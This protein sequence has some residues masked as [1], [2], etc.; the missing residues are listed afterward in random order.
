[1]R[2]KGAGEL[3]LGDLFDAQA[4]RTPDVTAVRHGAVGLTFGELADRVDRLAERLVRRGTRP[5][6][7]VALCVGRGV[8]MVT[9]LLAIVRAGGVLVPLDPRHPDERLRLLLRDCAAPLVLT[10]RDLAHRTSASGAD[11]VFVDAGAPGGAEPVP[12]D[13][14]TPV[15][16]AG[17][18]AAP[19][20]AV[21]G[22]LPLNAA[23]L[24]YASGSSGVPEGV[25][26]THAGLTD[27]F[28]RHRARFIG[29]ATRDAGG[30]RLRVAH[31]AALSSDA[32]WVPLLW[33][34]A[35]HELHVVDHDTHED[36]AAMLAYV[37]RHRID[38][39]DETPSLLRPLVAAGL[40]DA[41]RHRPSVI[42][43]GGGALDDELRAALAAA[44]GTR[45][46][47]RYGPAEATVDALVRPVRPGGRPP[48]GRPSTGVRARVLDG[49]LRP[50]PAGTP[51]ELYLAGPGLARGYHG[52]PGPTAARFTADPHGPAGSRLY[53]TGDLVRVR[54][55]GETEF[56]GRV[57]DQAQIQGVR[58]E[59]RE[60][61][62]ALLRH[63][64]VTGAEE[65]A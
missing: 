53:R 39:L 58:G 21:P 23:C 18:P 24:T 60:A 5:E 41:D 42:T 44:P 28:H 49:A 55:D 52:R 26:V 3:V 8:D 14:G 57:D 9:G 22:P 43:V 35:G 16:R 37:G 54:A 7:P 25:V 1:M 65:L 50:V 62:A 48:A 13:A 63:P 59:P 30:R 17:S 29:P 45:C 6:T 2:G 27:L 38:V 36:A 34:L 40:L 12:S 61:G 19:G 47:N 32:S 51:G 46:H 10:R 4:A 56:L 64:G 31:T 20:P 15:P 11:P 33:L